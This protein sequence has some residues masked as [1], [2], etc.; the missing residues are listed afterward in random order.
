MPDATAPAAPA[1]PPAAP[2]PAAAPPATPPP[3]PGEQKPPRPERLA[4]ERHELKNREARLAARQAEI[5]QRETNFKA[6][7]AQIRRDAAEFDR[8]RKLV[9]TGDPQAVLKAAGFTVD[10]V[11]K[12]VLEGDKRPIEQIVEERVQA[13]LKQTEEQKAEAYRQEQTKAQKEREEAIDRG[14]RTSIEDTIT[15]NPE[16]YELCMRDPS[17][18]E[19]AY[20]V[21]VAHHAAT[22][23]PKTGL[24]QVMKFDEALDHVEEAL[25]TSHLERNK[26]SK[27]V[28]AAL[29]T[30]LK[31]LVE[32]RVKEELTKLQS[33][34]FRAPQR[35]QQVAEPTSTAPGQQANSAPQAPPSRAE[36]MRRDR[37]KI[38]AVTKANHSNR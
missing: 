11:N 12:R 37:E 22:R 33:S 30:E 17:A 19:L 13:I 1:A 16:K 24:G 23:D 28:I 36:Q 14:L 18:V 25:L 21:I 10:D 35:V 32:A 3:P 26:T 15:G 4:R 20:E 6:V 5:D 38:A 29:E 27:K 34:R 8:F 9:Q 7:E 2:P 31:A